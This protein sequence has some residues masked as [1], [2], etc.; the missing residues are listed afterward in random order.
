[1]KKKILFAFTIFTTVSLLT[2]GCGKNSA[3]QVTVHGTTAEEAE[4]LPENESSVEESL[5]EEVI[6]TNPRP[7]ESITA[8]PDMEES[9]GS[10]ETSH[11]SETTDEPVTEE[12]EE[13]PEGAPVAWYDLF[14][15]HSNQPDLAADGEFKNLTLQPGNKPNQLYVTWFSKSSANGKVVFH[16]EKG[17]IHSSITAQAT[18][19]PSI[20]VPGYY[21]NNALI[22]GLE[23]NTVYYYTLKNGK[24]ESA[25]YKY[26]TRDLYATDFIFTVAGA[27]FFRIAISPFAL[28]F[29]SRK[30][31][32]LFL[33]LVRLLL[34]IPLGLSTVCHELTWFITIKTF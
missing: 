3:E 22:D 19:E 29:F 10:T 23:S 21:R 9:D 34:V 30:S 8:E 31:F 25:K 16:P 18:T 1:M 6:E 4:E 17:T 7:E 12:D 32:L 28:T 14:D 11:S 2:L 5:T 13:I 26:K 33:L 15:Y 27:S 20:S 24:N